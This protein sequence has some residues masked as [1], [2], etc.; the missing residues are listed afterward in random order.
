MI[1][2]ATPGSPTS[3]ESRTRSRRPSACSALV[4]DGRA[5][6]ILGTRGSRQRI[7]REFDLYAPLVPIGSYV[8]V[9]DT[10]VNGHPV[11]PGFGS[12]PDGSGE[13]HREQ[14][15][16]VLIGSRSRTLRVDL[17]S[18]R[19]SP[20]G[21]LARRSWVRATD[22]AR[23][24]NARHGHVAEVVMLLPRR[25]VPLTAERYIVG[26]HLVER[27]TG[28]TWPHHHGTDGTCPHR[29]APR[30]EPD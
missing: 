6:V 23:C 5:L 20:P 29:A 12:G 1:G 7:K 10:M 11:W 24:P 18:R 8:V 26:L 28:V 9:E 3:T 13:G 27:R 25:L 16:E 22:S 17:Q 21:A 15:G 2:R 30:A 19:L 14:A 4:G